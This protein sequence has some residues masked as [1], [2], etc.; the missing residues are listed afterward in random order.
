V[1][2]AADLERALKAKAVLDSPAF[3]DSFENVRKAIIDS[4]ERCSLK[5]TESAEHFR[6][7]LKLLKDVRLNL[8]AAINSG[9]LASFRLNEEKER[10]ENPLRRMF[11]DR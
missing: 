6:I 11:S 2:D 4:I 10:R 1:S 7:C 9:K 8:E 5:D 3:I